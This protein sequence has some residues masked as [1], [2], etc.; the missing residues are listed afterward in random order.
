MGR[1]RPKTRKVRPPAAELTETQRE[2]KS[3]PTIE[4]LLEKA[5][6]LIIQCDYD[7]AGRFAERVLKRAP[8]NVEGKEILGVVQLETG[9]LDA[10]KQTFLSLL[11][12]NPGAPSPPP[13]AV[14]LYLAQLS[15]NDPQMALKHFAAAVDILTLQLKGKDRAA[16]FASVK[17]DEDEARRTIV[18]A[19]IGQVEIWMDPA[20]DLCFDPA[21]ESN[22]E[23]LLKSALQIDPENTEALQTLASVRMS[24]QRPDEAKEI[25]EKAWSSW[26][27]LDADDPQLPP[28]AS[29][30]N[31]TKLFLELSLFTPALMVLQGIMASDDEEVEAWYLEGWCFFLMAEQAREQGGKLDELTWEEL[32]RDSRDC[33]ETCKTLH[34]NQGHPDL[35]I[36]EHVKELISK[37]EELGVK[38]S[39][40]DD[41]G[42]DGDWE[43][44]EGSDDS[45]SD[46]EMS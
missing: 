36:R 7:L 44:Y 20:Y 23:E 34:I 19:L 10:A 22:C 16:D 27:D 24:Q 46:V 2:S 39:P 21:A 18:R 38:P 41:G 25:L 5:Q 13:P 3:E 30:L 33:L 28:I 29:R 1:T 37:L 4:A 6:E 12:P 35:P 9:L 45:E 43:D 14:H 42:D 17:N 11:P 40:E 8:N 32:A 31:L 26:K 15:D